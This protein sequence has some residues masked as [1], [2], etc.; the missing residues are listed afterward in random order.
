MSSRPLVPPSAVPP[1]ALS[2][3]ASALRLLVS[4]T[5]LGGLLGA[6]TTAFARE[7]PFADKLGSV[8]TIDLKDKVEVPLALNGSGDPVSSV[9]VVVNGKARGIQEAQATSVMQR[10]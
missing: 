6:S 3:A 10:Y 5:L 2:P 8:G 7:L 9:E 1:C 4:A